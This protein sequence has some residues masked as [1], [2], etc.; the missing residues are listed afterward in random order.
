MI[1]GLS[2]V[3]T[4][5]LVTLVHPAFACS[6]GGLPKSKDD[7]EVWIAGSD[8]V[9][10]VY[11]QEH[12]TR[13]WVEGDLVKFDSYVHTSVVRSFKGLPENSDI[14]FDLNSD[15]TCRAH[16]QLRYTYVVFAKGPGPNGRFET[17][18]C[19]MGQFRANI[20]DDSHREHNKLLQKLITPTI[21][22]IQEAQE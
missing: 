7:A 20:D 1:R 14:Y 17:S 2:V 21:D 19:S 18:M 10:L 22:A 13:K 16:F 11:V 9:A 4:I 8:L 15:S 3:L 12:L 5:A 6:C